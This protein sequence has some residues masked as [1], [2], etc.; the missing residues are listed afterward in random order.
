MWQGRPVFSAGFQGGRSRSGLPGTRQGRGASLEQAVWCRG[1]GAPVP[2]LPACAQE[3]AAPQVTSRVCPEALC[4]PTPG[5]SRAVPQ[6]SPSRPVCSPRDGGRAGSWLPPGAPCRAA[7]HQPPATG[8]RGGAAG[9]PLPLPRPCALLSLWNAGGPGPAPRAPGRPRMERPEPGRPDRPAGR[10]RY[11]EPAGP[12]PAQPRERERERGVWPGPRR[13]VRADMRLRELSLRQDPD[14]RQE[15]ASLARGC[16]FVLPSRFKK[17]LKAFRQVQTKKEEPLP[18]ASSESIPAF[19]FPRGRPQDTVNVDAVIA[20]IERTFAQFPHERATVEDMG[21]VAKVHSMVL[22]TR[23]FPRRTLC[24]RSRLVR[25]GGSRSAR[26][27]GPRT[28]PTVW[29]EARQ[30]RPAEVTRM[31]GPFR[32]VCQGVETSLMGRRK[33]VGKRRRS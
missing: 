9:R 19:Y 32:P 25:P 14:L 3:L 18:P 33:R 27:V 31:L 28:S 21:R 6:I 12:G 2:A 24:W 17:R 10:S 30:C 7:G 15:L 22:C 20:K 16:D 4:T 8:P 1:Q 5:T 11:P 29:A 26:S 13:P 23:V